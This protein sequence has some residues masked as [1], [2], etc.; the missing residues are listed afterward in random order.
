MGIIY[1]IVS[2][3]FS[4]WAYEN[5]KASTIEFGKKYILNPQS[6]PVDHQGS[7]AVLVRKKVKHALKEGVVVKEYR[8]GILEIES[9]IESIAK[10]WVEKREGPQIFLCHVSLFNDREGRRYF[11][12][13]KEGKIVGFLLLN[14]LK[15]KEGWLLNN[16]MMVKNAPK[17]LSELLII[18]TLQALEKESCC[19]V[20]VGPVPAE[21]L[22]R[23]L[24][25]GT[26]G[27]AVIQWVFQ[28]AKNIFH[29]KGHETFWDKFEPEIESSFLI[30][31]KKNLNF[32][33][34]KSLMKAFNVKMG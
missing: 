20:L 1:T 12:A 33:S 8:G 34:V 26:I 22:G 27:K 25:V 5:L 10:R 32:S 7:K 17:G 3:S 4:K 24:G 31:P 15:A 23:V 11:Y 28:A 29:L 30:F 21:N 19:Y 9:Q 6:N 2:D 16:V 18:S 14:E 13:E